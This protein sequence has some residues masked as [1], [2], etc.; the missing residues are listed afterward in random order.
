MNELASIISHG[1]AIGALLPILC[2]GGVGI[3]LIGALAT[4]LLAALDK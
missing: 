1:A 2:I 4:M 3:G